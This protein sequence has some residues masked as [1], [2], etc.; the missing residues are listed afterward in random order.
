MWAAEDSWKNAERPETRPP[1]PY[2]PLTRLPSPDLP[3]V[4]PDPAGS[5]TAAT[6]EGVSRVLASGVSAGPDTHR[7]QVHVCTGLPACFVAA[8][9][10]RTS[11]VARCLP[12]TQLGELHHGMLLQHAGLLEPSGLHSHYAWIELSHDA[13]GAL[14]SGRSELYLA[15]P[16]R[17]IRRLRAAVGCP[18]ANASRQ[19]MPVWQV[20]TA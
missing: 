18:P 11:Q 5:T 9:T 17:R 8:V 2:L 6:A 1:L 14:C 4:F 3:C 15:V 16:D 13:P 20:R 10:Y 7:S 12:S 19:V